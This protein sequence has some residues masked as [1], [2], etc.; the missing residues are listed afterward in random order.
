MVKAVD[1][2][3]ILVSWGPPPIETRNGEITQYLLIYSLMATPTDEKL[4]TFV[5][6][7]GLVSGLSP[8]TPYL[9]SVAAM[10]VALGPVSPS[11]AQRPYSLPPDPPEDPPGIPDDAAI[12]TTTI[13]INLPQ[14]NTSLFRL[15][16]SVL[17]TN[18]D[19]PP[20]SLSLSLSHF[21]VVAI[22]LSDVD[23]SFLQGSPS[24]EFPNSQAFLSYSEGAISAQPQSST[25]AATHFS[26]LSPDLPINSPYIVTEVSAAGYDVVASGVFVLGDENGT[27]SSNDFPEQ[28][29]NGPLEEGTRYTVFVWG[30]LPAISASTV[31]VCLV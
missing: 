13:P 21:W 15:A 14:M 8:D 4:S 24:N 5:G 27:R 10:T 9:F 31:S 11:L 19:G 3:R 18:F 17:S 6:T 2:E 7:E 22:K 26:S 30:F 29:R 1:T 12:T 28:Y 16:E 20:L 23:P 25:D